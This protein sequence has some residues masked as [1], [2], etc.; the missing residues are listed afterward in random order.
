MLR[1]ARSFGPCLAVAV[2]LVAVACG[3][4]LVSSGDTAPT[5]PARVPAGPPASGPA[6]DSSLATVEEIPGWEEVVRDLDYREC[7]VYWRRAG[8]EYSLEVAELAYSEEAMSGP[9]HAVQVATL[10]RP[11]SEIES[12]IGVRAHC[13]FPYTEAGHEE[14]LEHLAAMF[15]TSVPGEDAS[16]D[17]GGAQADGDDPVVCDKYASEGKATHQCPKITVSVP[18]TCPVGFDRDEYSGA[19]VS[20]IGGGPGI[21]PTDPGGLGPG[22]SA[23]GGNNNNDDNNDDEEDEEPEEPVCTDDQIAIAGEY[24]DSDNWPCTKFG[25]PVTTHGKRGDPNIGVDGHD[26]GYLDWSY[27]SGAGIVFTQASLAGVTGIGVESDWRCPP[28]NAAIPGS[29]SGSQHVLGTAGDF[30][31][32]N[33]DADVSEGFVAAARMALAGYVYMDVAHA[34]IDWG[35]KRGSW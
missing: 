10:L 31:S 27:M 2:V 20:N 18:K 7:A 6:A 35:P 30:Y 19:C 15:P 16:A 32:D 29:S 34:H 23:P 1:L 24:G 25:W 11:V 17:V 3:E 9:Y 12:R 28:G 5:L 21:S 33:F 4:S 22:G 14:M 26:T 13:L 8:G